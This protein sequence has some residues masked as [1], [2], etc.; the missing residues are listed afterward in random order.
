MSVAEV[1][2]LLNVAPLYVVLKLTRT[3]ALGPVF[4]RRGRRY[5]LRAK[6]EAYRRKQRRIA[7]RALRELAHE[8][9]E[10]GLYETTKLGM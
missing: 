6:V 4:I 8:S 10:A 9:Q 1:A 3:R 7:G 2:E 5:I